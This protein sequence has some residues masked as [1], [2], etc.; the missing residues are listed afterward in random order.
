MNRRHFLKQLGG[1]AAAVTLSP[2]LDLAPI[3]YM[4]GPITWNDRL[5]LH[6]APVVG[7]QQWH[8][9]MIFFL[10]RQWIGV[11]RGNG[12]E[13]LSAALPSTTKRNTF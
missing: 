6:G 2:L 12:W 9:N 7:D 1:A 5:W 11:N 10:G 8:Q 4:S 3:E 13:C